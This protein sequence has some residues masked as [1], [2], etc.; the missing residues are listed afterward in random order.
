MQFLGLPVPIPVRPGGAVVGAV[1]DAH[2]AMPWQ[3]RIA[4]TSHL[5]SHDTPRFRTVTGGGTSG[6]VDADG[7]GRERH[8]LGLALQ[9]TLPG[10]PVVFMGDDS[11]SP[12][13]TA[14]TPA[15]RCP[16]NGARSGTS[17]RT[18]PT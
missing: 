16:G 2:A 18:T 13:S 7:L 3:S 12:D 8:L 4:S 14:S 9:M 6:W 1:R 15:R 11:A 5:D 17:R 10:I